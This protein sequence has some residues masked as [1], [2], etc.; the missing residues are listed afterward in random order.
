MSNWLH[1]YDSF[2][3][4]VD[5]ASN[6][7]RFAHRDFSG[8][9]VLPSGPNPADCAVPVPCSIECFISWYLES[10]GVKFTIDWEWDQGLMRMEFIPFDKDLKTIV[11]EADAAKAA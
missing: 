2:A 8:C 4:M 11:N 1:M 7:N 10:R 6:P 3:Q 9:D 5:L